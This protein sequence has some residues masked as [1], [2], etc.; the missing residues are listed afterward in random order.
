MLCLPGCTLVFL[1]VCLLVC[2]FGCLVV[3][4]RTECVYAVQ[5]SKQIDRSADKHRKPHVQADMC[6]C[7]GHPGEALNLDIKLLQHIVQTGFAH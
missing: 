3:Q 6:S 2:N 1:S 7:Q 4:H 5:T